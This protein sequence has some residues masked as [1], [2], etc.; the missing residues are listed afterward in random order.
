MLELSGF[1]AAPLAQ[2]ISRSTPIPIPYT[3]PIDWIRLL[4]T[5]TAALGMILVLRFISPLVQNKWAW[6]AITVV[7]ILV[8]NSGFMYARI[9]GVPYTGPNGQWIAAGYQNQ[10]GQEVHVIAFICV[11][12]PASTYFA[13][14]P[15]V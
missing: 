2:V 13:N 12:S 6:A 3:E 15:H 5:A 9:R 10:F 4:V 14:S 11:S 7:T 8:M 1:D